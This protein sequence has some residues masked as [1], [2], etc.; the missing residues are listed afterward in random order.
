MNYTFY[1]YDPDSFVLDFIEAIC[2][3]ETKS[4]SWLANIQPC[5]LMKEN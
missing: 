2:Q 1:K 5:E 3:T 4:L